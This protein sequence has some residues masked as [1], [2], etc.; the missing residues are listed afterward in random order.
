MTRMQRASSKSI[1]QLKMWHTRDLTF[2]NFKTFS[3]EEEAF[4]AIKGIN[5]QTYTGQKLIVDVLS[6]R[7][8][9]KTGPNQDDQCFKC[10]KGGHWAHLCPKQDHQDVA[11]EDLIRDLNVIEDLILD[12]NLHTHLIEIQQ[13]KQ[14]KQK[15]ETQKKYKKRQKTKKAK[16]QSQT[17]TL[18]FRLIQKAESN[19]LIKSGKNNFINQLNIIHS[20]LS[21][22]YKIIKKNLQDLSQGQDQRYK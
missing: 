6:N 15:K 16:Y 8:V 17:I 19:I 22:K 9:K 10:G 7:K 18:S 20:I 1:Q 21:H 5:G 12:H 13:K 2:F 14:Q 4:E 3:N 11:E